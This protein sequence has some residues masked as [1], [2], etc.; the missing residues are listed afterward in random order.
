MMWQYSRRDTKFL[1]LATL[2]VSSGFGLMLS[3]NW[4]TRAEYPV[5]QT[6]TANS[7]GI[8]ASVPPNEVNTLASQLEERE[9]DITARE[10]ILARS[11][12]EDTRTLAVVSLMGAG[13]LGLILMNFYL[14]NRRRHSLA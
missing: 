13:L 3:Q 6:L 10:A 8:L 4:Q 9:R 11:A 14:D 12:R 2:L 7:V 5:P 1:L